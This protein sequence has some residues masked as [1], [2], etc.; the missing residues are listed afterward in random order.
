MQ[1]AFHHEAVGTDRGEDVIHLRE[2]LDDTLAFERARQVEKNEIGFR[3]FFT[4]HLVGIV[5]RIGCIACNDGVCLFLH[6]PEVI[7]GKSLEISAFG[8][9]LN[10][11]CPQVGDAVLRGIAIDDRHVVAFH[12]MEIACRKDGKRSFPNATF[13]CGECNKDFLVHNIAFLSC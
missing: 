8:D 11:P 13:L 10:F 4:Q 12:V 7:A 6:P 2:R 9:D 1:R 5:E 3:R